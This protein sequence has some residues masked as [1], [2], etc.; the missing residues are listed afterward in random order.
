MHTLPGAGRNLRQGLRW[1]LFVV[2]LIATATGTL[3]VLRS[4]RHRTDALRT[5]RADR[6]VIA[7]DGRLRCVVRSMQVASNLLDADADEQGPWWRHVESA[8]LNRNCPGLVGMVFA[9]V[10]P[11]S[12]L[13]DHLHGV[14]QYAGPGYRVTP[15]G[16]RDRYVPVVWAAMRRGSANS[17]LGFDLAS[18]PVR[19][20]VMEHVPSDGGSTAT[21]PVMLLQGAGAEGRRGVELLLPVRTDI[22]GTAGGAEVR[23]PVR[24]YIAAEIDVAELVR[25]VADASGTRMLVGVYDGPEQRADTVLYVEELAAQA[26]NDGV[27]VA[28]TLQFE[29]RTWT[30]DLA[31]TDR[32]DVMVPLVIGFTGVSCALAVFAGMRRDASLHPR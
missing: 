9:P 2:V 18:D 6:T 14:R 12:R 19:R 28:R 7:L 27:R 5:E 4:E 20:G 10:V 31:F 8:A 30:L 26:G 24:G 3:S 22:H 29:G 32:T 25:S 13:A 23:L 11:A 17:A 15:E 1:L 16:A 21:P